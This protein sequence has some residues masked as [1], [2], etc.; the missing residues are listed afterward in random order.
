MLTTNQHQT[1]APTA[2]LTETVRKGVR[3]SV[4]H[5]FWQI[6][7]ASAMCTVCMNAGCASFSDSNSPEPEVLAPPDLELTMQ[8]GWEK[9]VELA[10]P[11]ESDR[12]EYDDHHDGPGM[13]QVIVEISNNPDSLTCL[14]SDDESSEIEVA[15]GQ[16][17]VKIMVVCPCGCGF[18]QTFDEP[19]GLT[20]YVFTYPEDKTGPVLSTS[21]PVGASSRSIIRDDLF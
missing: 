15:Y 7:L 21:F 3:L 4:I 5:K 18:D 14:R 13:G 8:V 9:G 6:G 16:N 11:N 1:A 12:L 2:R 10:G 17:N 19:T 20:S